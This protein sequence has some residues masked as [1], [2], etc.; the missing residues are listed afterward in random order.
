MGIDN[1]HRD[2]DTRIHA[3]QSTTSLKGSWLAVSDLAVAS[4]FGGFFLHRTGPLLAVSDGL[5]NHK[6]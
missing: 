5:P 2:V 4:R 3:Y 1:S 6:K